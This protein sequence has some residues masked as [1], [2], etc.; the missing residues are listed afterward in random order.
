MLEYDIIN[1]DIYDYKLNDEAYIFHEFK[2]SAAHV[3]SY[4]KKLKPKPELRS[5]GSFLLQYQH[6][7]ILL[8]ENILIS[9]GHKTNAKITSNSVYTCTYDGIMTNL[10]L[11]PY[12][13]Q[14]D[15]YYK[16]V[17]GPVYWQFLH[18]T[19]ILCKT[20][21]QKDF[22]STNMYNFNLCLLCGICAFNFKK[23]NPFLLMM[24]ISLTGDSITQI[25]RLHNMVNSALHKSQYSFEDFQKL[26]KLEVVNQKSKKI[27]YIYNKNDT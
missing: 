8:I 21:Y 22:F 13:L 24:L 25:F 4:I 7:W 2:K 12:V 19:S 5:C 23:K 26:F 9:I 20:Q 11:Q 14:D 1:V 18:L 27:T 15:E 10:N 16:N 6:N 3:L 17:W